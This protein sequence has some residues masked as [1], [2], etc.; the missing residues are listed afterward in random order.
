[1]PSTLARRSPD[2]PIESVELR[3]SFRADRDTTEAIK[4]AIPSAVLRNGVCILKIEGEQ[5]GDVA[6]R[7]REVLEKIRA[8]AGTSKGFK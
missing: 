3:I 4:Q 1:M 8:M 7:A 5:P 2:R 6:E